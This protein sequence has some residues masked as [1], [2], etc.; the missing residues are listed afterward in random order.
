MARRDVNTG[1][2]QRQMIAAML[3][4]PQGKAMFPMMRRVD[5]AVFED[6]LSDVA[7]RKAVE[8]L[9]RYYGRFKALPSKDAW[10]DWR[11]KDAPLVRWLDG[12]PDEEEDSF[13]LLEGVMHKPPKDPE[14][15]VALLREF[16]VRMFAV[17][18]AVAEAQLLAGTDKQPS[19]VLEEGRAAREAFA[20]EMDAALSGGEREYSE[21][22][23]V[24]D[25]TGMLDTEPIRTCIS[26]LNL[27][28]RGITV[29]A[30]PPKSFKTGIVQAVAVGLARDG[31]DV[32]FV[33]L[34][35]GRDKSRRRFYQNMLNCTKEEIWAG[36]VVDRARV[37]L[38][39]REAVYGKGDK[40]AKI[41]AWKDDEGKWHLRLPEFTAM[42]DG[43]EL[44]GDWQETGEL[45]V[46]RSTGPVEGLLQAE[47]DRL[48]G[49]LGLEYV[50]GASVARIGQLAGLFFAATPEGRRKVVVIDWGQHLRN[51]DKKLNYWEKIR[52]NYAQLKELRDRLDV[53]VLMIEAPKEYA[54]LGDAM[55]RKK[56]LKMAGTENIGFDVEALHVLLATEEE[57]EKGWRRMMVAED[58]DADSG[59]H[60]VS[61]LKLDYRCMQV[62]QVTADEHR[63]ACPQF[64]AERDGTGKSKGKGGAGGGAMPSFKFKIRASDASDE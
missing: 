19:E 10:Q 15:A 44:T 49:R 62:A 52:D 53:S 4:T 5:A 8:S 27:Y 41:E 42:V 58:R 56:D 24:V 13:K 26:K 25:L 2:V 31:C 30:A 16:I 39:D 29:L 9:G 40:V 48:E 38:H 57:R 51:P 7:A 11:R 14:Y 45:D 12:C 46:D 35:N 60:V 22:S 36:R 21:V 32:Y 55:F 50:K 1:A 17:G 47:L 33:D 20:A 61:F 64:W 59:D 54:K 23:G 18:Q 28:R 43:A 6:Q 37:R 34:E 63:Y 3:T